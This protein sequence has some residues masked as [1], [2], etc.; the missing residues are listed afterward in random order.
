MTATRLWSSRPEY[1][2]PVLPRDIQFLK[3][4]HHSLLQRT[5]SAGLEYALCYSYF[6]PARHNNT[7]TMAQTLEQ[8]RRNAKFAKGQEA[9]MGK[10]EDQVKN[11]VKEA[12]KVPISMFW[13]AILGFA[14]F[15]G[16]VFE[17][18]SHMFG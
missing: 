11:R 16:L 8:R 1:L 12:P 4:K 2:S 7:D 3:Y 17:A 13:V 18:I 5:S 9:R 15:G 6:Q 10:S 14:V